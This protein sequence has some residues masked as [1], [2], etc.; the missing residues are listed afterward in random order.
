MNRGAHG[1]ANILDRCRRIA[2]LAR[3]WDDK[4]PGEGNRHLEPKRRAKSRRP[5][6]AARD[7]TGLSQMG[8][9]GTECEEVVH[10]R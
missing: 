5:A 4:R 7:V 3:G 8:L 6:D 10:N 1:C 9:A 2:S